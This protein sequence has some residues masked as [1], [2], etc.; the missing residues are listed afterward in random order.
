MT[1]LIPSSVAMGKKGKGAG[2]YCEG[3]NLTYKASL[4][5]VDYLNSKQHLVTTGKIAKAERAT[6]ED[7]L[8]WLE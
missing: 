4:Q 3:C 2:F 5:W 6:L 1:Q 8:K 7:V